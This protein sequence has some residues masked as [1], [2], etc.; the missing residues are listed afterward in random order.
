MQ[1]G[2]ALNDRSRK[3]GVIEIRLSP[4]VAGPN[5]GQQRRDIMVLLL[6]YGAHEIAGTFRFVAL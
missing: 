2:D 5:Y 3:K 4:R 6:R 1:L